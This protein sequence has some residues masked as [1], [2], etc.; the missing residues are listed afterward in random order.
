LSAEKNGTKPSFSFAKTHQA[1]EKA[2]EVPV[3]HENHRQATGIS[4]KKSMSLDKLP[5][6]HEQHHHDV[7]LM[8]H[9]ED[10]LG[11]DDFGEFKHAHSVSASPPQ[12]KTINFANFKKAQNDNNAQQQAQPQAQPQGQPAQNQWAW[13]LTAPQANPQVQVPSSDANVTA[14]SEQKP[15]ENKVD[16]MKLYTQPTPVTHHNHFM[17]GGMYPQPQWNGAMQGNYNN[18]WNNGM[19]MNGGFNNGHMGHQAN[20][21]GGYPTQFGGQPGFNPNMGYNQVQMNPHGN[22]G[23]NQAQ[24]GNNLYQNNGYMQTQN[25]QNKLF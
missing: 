24:L 17:Q 9:D 15:A 19:N 22:M 3:K 1:T 21:Q 8:S 7:D 10:L 13:D 25:V 16:L 5:S 20:F 11:G 6:K 18:G 12:K 2:E 14:Q 23:Y 4:R